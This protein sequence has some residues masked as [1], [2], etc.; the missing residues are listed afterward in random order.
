MFQVLSLDPVRQQSIDT[1]IITT[2]DQQ[3]VWDHILFGGI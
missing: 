3:I 2:G 1:I